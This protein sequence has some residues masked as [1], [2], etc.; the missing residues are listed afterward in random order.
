MITIYIVD[1]EK[2]I[3]DGLHHL[4]DW[5]SLGYEIIG[6]SGHS[7]D[8]QRAILALLPDLVI[9]DI[10]MSGMN[11]I[12]LIR[13]LRNSGYNGQ[14]IIISGY[15]DFEYAKSAI[16]FGVKSY[17]L[18][19]IDERELAGELY[20]LRRDF[21]AR[22]STDNHINAASF[23][24]QRWLRYLEQ[25]DNQIPS[26]ISEEQ[27]FH[28]NNT[29]AEIRIC[30]FQSPSKTQTLFNNEIPPIPNMLNK[31]GIFAKWLYIMPHQ[32]VLITNQ[33][34]TSLKDAVDIIIKQHVLRDDIACLA[35]IGKG[36]GSFAD[37]RESFSSA[38]TL[39]DHAFIYAQQN[40]IVY[41]NTV[42]DS[43]DLTNISID[44]LINSIIDHISEYK[45]NDIRSE[46]ESYEGYFIA[47]RF[48]E[49][50]IKIHYSN[51]YS[52]LIS[53]IKER[54]PLLSASV[55]NYQQF[56]EQSYLE[57]NITK[58]TALLLSH[59][60]NITA[61]VSEQQPEGPIN[62]AIYLINKNYA[63]NLTVES[64]SKQ[65]HYNPVY[66]GRKFKNCTGET[67]GS[68]VDKVRIEHAKDLLKHD[69]KVNVVSKMV[70]F[71]NADYFG[72]KFKQYTG[73]SPRDYQ[74]MCLPDK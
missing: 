9:T 61:V 4:L 40:I 14:F 63:D 26:D 57:T 71:T 44:H 17:I 43:S 3:R 18:K 19:P 16:H 30:I 28:N 49:L 31:Q 41:D 67:F 48:N 12:E 15:A 21:I 22:N 55:D 54:Y 73:V 36:V 38:K 1:D 42:V 64:V 34:V 33:D 66:F 47:N 45:L 65:L 32:A 13:N 35:A 58:L 29:N 60:K 53:A 10:K 72:E 27:S 5:T 24:E 74:H 20:S 69:Q 56:I 6:E 70:G 52:Q 50:E 51:M 7:E 46:F 25:R 39:L 62:K 59:L 8:A 37:I 11:G 2:I 23:M 68:Y